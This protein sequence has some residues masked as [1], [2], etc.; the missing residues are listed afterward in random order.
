MFIFFIENTHL[1]FLESMCFIMQM[2]LY[3]FGFDGT[4]S[5]GYSSGIPV[6]ITAM[7]ILFLNI[8]HSFL[9]ICDK[10]D[11]NVISVSQLSYNWLACPCVCCTKA[12]FSF[13]I[14]VFGV[15]SNLAGKMLWREFWSKLPLQKS[16]SKLKGT[17]YLKA[18]VTASETLI[19]I[20]YCMEF[21]LNVG[22]FVLSWFSLI[23]V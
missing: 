10:E 12:A 15:I 6:A 7:R 23:S 3:S 5:H 1:F 9:K 22:N 14:L 20:E 21:L 19:Y 13:Y 11:Q 16:L 8:I 4:L 18:V 17:G 2:F